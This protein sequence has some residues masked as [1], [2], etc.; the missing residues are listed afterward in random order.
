MKLIRFIFLLTLFF[1]TNAMASGTISGIVVKVTDGDTITLLSLDGTK[2]KIRLAEIDAPEKRQLYGTDAK[3]EL[4]Y[5]TYGKRAV[6]EVQT[7]DRYGRTV[8]RVTCDG[9]D[10]SS[11]MVRRGYAWVYRQYSRDRSLVA[12]EDAAKKGGLGLWASPAVEPWVW[13]KNKK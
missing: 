7:V 3:N 13:R 11:E 9:Y 12:L 4:F 2:T 5:M 6:V 8:G 1:T 10:I